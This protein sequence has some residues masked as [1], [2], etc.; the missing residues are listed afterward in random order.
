MIAS[1][2]AA[3]SAADPAQ[4]AILQS[5]RKLSVWG[6]LNFLGGIALILDLPAIVCAFILKQDSDDLLRLVGTV[7]F[8]CGVI[9]MI[10]LMMAVPISEGHRHEAC[11]RLASSDIAV[12]QAFLV[13][14][15]SDDFPGDRGGGNPFRG[16]SAPLLLSSHRPSGRVVALNSVFSA[17]W[18]TAVVVD[19]R[20]KIE[21]EDGFVIKVSNAVKG[22][23]LLFVAKSFMLAIRTASNE[24]ASK[25][26]R[27]SS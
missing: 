7:G 19:C 13:R 22:E 6:W 18:E 21:N 24:Y 9:L 17:L 26:A 2:A 8:P 15:D 23:A 3:H 25:M 14:P 16:C 11:L 4:G 20:K 1:H 10:V 5:S 27:L 12:G